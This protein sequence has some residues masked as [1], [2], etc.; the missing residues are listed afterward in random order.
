MPQAAAGRRGRHA[1]LWH[2]YTTHVDMCTYTY[3]YAYT[4]AMDLRVYT[5]TRE[6]SSSHQSW[7]LIPSKQG[8]NGQSLLAHTRTVYGALRGAQTARTVGPHDVTADANACV[9]SA[10]D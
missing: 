9:L 7:R 8:K 2:A 10:C 5:R 3:I 1:E 6:A 4:C